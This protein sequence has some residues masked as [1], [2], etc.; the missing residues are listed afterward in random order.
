[1]EIIVA[2]SAGIDS[3][4]GIM[5]WS[6]GIDSPASWGTSSENVLFYKLDSKNTTEIFHQILF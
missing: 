6:A 2:W 4:P 1:M 3:Q 5:A